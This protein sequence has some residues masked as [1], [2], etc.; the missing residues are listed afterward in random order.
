MSRVRDSGPVLPGVDGDGREF[1][2]S[3]RIV[4]GAG[5]AGVAPP[6][7]VVER[8]ASLS[9]FVGDDSWLVQNRAVLI[10]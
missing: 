7:R 1:V 6:G 2:E 10:P 4:G 8:R 5:D 3:A 9:G